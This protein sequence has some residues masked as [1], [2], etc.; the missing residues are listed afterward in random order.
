MSQ[1]EGVEESMAPIEA[2]RAPVPTFASSAMV[3]NEVEQEDPATNLDTRRRQLGKRKASF[4]PGRATPKIPQVVAY[5]DSSSRDEKT[6][7]GFDETVT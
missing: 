5:A 6:G 3:G 1:Q 4:S 7:V 2:S